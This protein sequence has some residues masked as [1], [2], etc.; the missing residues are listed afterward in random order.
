MNNA[1][2]YDLGFAFRN[3][4][5]WK[6]IYE[7]ELFAVKLPLEG[8]PIGYCCV[9]GRDGTHMALAVYIGAEGF[10]SYRIIA[11]CDPDCYE[12]F[13][14]GIYKQNCVQCSVEREDMLQD[15][16]L[17]ALRKYCKKS[18]TPFRPPFPQFTRYYP[19]CVPWM[20]KTSDDWK[21]IETALL[22]V[23]KLAAEIKKRGK[24]QLGIRPI[25]VGL[26]DED[27]A[28]EYPGLFDADADEIVTIPLYS[29]VDGQLMI[30]RIQ[31]PPYMENDV[32]APDCINEI[33]TAKLMEN[34][35]RGTLECEI[36]RMP[37]PIYGDPPYFPAIMMAV[38][39]TGYA[40][41]PILTENNMYDPNEMINNFI[42][43]L[44][45]NYPKK[46]KVRTEETRIVLEPFCKKANICLDETD[47][48]D[49]L[50]EA[51]ESMM[52]YFDAGPEEE[53]EF[54]IEDMVDFLDSLTVEQIRMMPDS[55][56]DQII[57]DA[58]LFPRKI[59][60]KIRKA[61]KR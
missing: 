36:V 46:I 29:I 20:V 8:D 28:T 54:D 43:S 13:I 11:N 14:P 52:D 4:K 57:E 41:T 34:A 2:F 15:E 26:Y 59:I 61:R 35:Q 3:S 12:G 7:E 38:D 37:S 32:E 31:L 44:G 1:Y 48:M 40:F 18:G 58:E 55:I 17:D 23:Q 16:E 6:Y 42:K 5:I 27:Y 24:E 49:F 10:T 47:S 51:I 39:E 22:V 53:D 33:A 56:L 50:D 21:S 30:E 9:M 45:K 60:E 19:Y 25:F